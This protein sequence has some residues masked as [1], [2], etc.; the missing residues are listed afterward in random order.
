M[1]GSNWNED[2]P[3]GPKYIR[4]ISAGHETFYPPE[5]FAKQPPT[6]AAD[7]YMLAKC[8]VR[9]LGEG[10]MLFPNV[11]VGR[12][13][14]IPYPVRRF[15]TDCLAEN[16]ASR[17]QSAWQMHEDF[18]KILREVVG[19]PHYREFHMPGVTP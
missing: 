7:I 6:P 3:D 12:R 10:S 8:A 15:I 18:D 11:K 9:L 1:G 19:K 14:T 16:P 5:V 2:F 17:P 4:D 13:P